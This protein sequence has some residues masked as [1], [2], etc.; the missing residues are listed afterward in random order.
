MKKK[1]EQLSKTTDNVVNA[2]D[3]LALVSVSFQNGSTSQFCN[4]CAP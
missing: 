3:V 1:A 4:P 2:F